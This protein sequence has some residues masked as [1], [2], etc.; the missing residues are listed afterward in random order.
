LVASHE[1]YTIEPKGDEACIL[2]LSVDATF[3]GGMSEE[4]IAMEV[5]MMTVACGNALEKLKIQ[6]EQGVEA[7]HR[8]EAQQMDG[9]ED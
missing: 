2:S 4:Q 1:T 7:V 3:V 6:A 8:I 5:M 9:F